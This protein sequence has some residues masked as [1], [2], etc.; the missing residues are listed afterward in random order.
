VTPNVAPSW[1]PDG[2]QHAYTARDAQGV[3]QINVVDALGGTPRSLSR[4]PAVADEVWTGGWGPHGRIVFDRTVNPD[5]AETGIIH[6]NLAS[7]ALLITAVLVAVVLVLAAG[8]GLPFGSLTAAALIGFALASVPGMEWRFAPVGLAVGLGA[9]LVAWRVE[10]AWRSRVIGALAAATVVIGSG[11][12][13]LF[14]ATLAWSPTLL[15][16]VAAAAAAAGWALGALASPRATGTI[17]PTA[18]VPAPDG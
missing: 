7:A 15:I 11:L 4:E 12:V 9:D 17:T 3:G 2:R 6:E 8:V 14:T 16:G 18:A 13:V 10:S 5:S 1:S